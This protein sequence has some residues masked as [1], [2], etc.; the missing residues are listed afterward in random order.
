MP[1]LPDSNNLRKIVTL[2]FVSHDFL[3]ELYQR[4][5]S[6]GL[7]HP[8]EMIV[9]GHTWNEIQSAQTV[10]LSVPPVE[11]PAATAEGTSEGSQEP[12]DPR[13]VR[14]DSQTTPRQL[15]G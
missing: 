5:A 6:A 9:A 12:S 3:A 11:P 8:S 7:I 1:N 13:A 10:Q 4:A 15:T 2:H 14:R